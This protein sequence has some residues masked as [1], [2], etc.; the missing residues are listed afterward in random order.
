MDGTAPAIVNAI[1][2]ALGT[3]LARLP[4]TPERILAALAARPTS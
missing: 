4:A 1:N 3:A 2:A